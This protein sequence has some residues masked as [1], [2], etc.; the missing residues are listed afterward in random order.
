MMQRLLFCVLA[1]VCIAGSRADAAELCDRTGQPIDITVLPTWP[2]PPGLRRQ[3]VLFVHGHAADSS[4]DPNYRK[5][6]WEDADDDPLLAFFDLTSVKKTLDDT[7]NSGLDIEAYYIRFDDR[8]RSITDDAFET[9]QVVDYIVRR[10]N[11]NFDPST[12]TMPPPVQVAIIGYSKGTISTRQYLKSLQ[13]QVQDNGGISLPPPRPGYRPVSEFIALAQPNHGI[14]SSFFSEATDQI[15]IQQLYN[16]VQPEGPGCGTPFPNLHPQAANFIEILNGEAAIDLQVSNA[17]AAS[18]EAPGSRPPDQGPHTGT[19]YVT[20]FDN[21]DLVGGNSP[22]STDCPGAGRGLASN[23]S[24]QAINITTTVPGAL[25]ATVHRNTPHAQDVVCKALFAVIHHRS[26]EN[27][28]CPLSGRVPIIPLPQP[29]AAMLALD[30]SGSMLARECATCPTRYDILKQA[31]EIF[32][33]LWSLAGRPNDRLGVT[34]FRTTVDEPSIASERL[35]VLTGNAA[36][37]V[38]DVTKPVA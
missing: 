10:H 30:I 4:A 5:N 22:S 12:A 37:V 11:E 34:Y 19:L 1:M 26:P 6:F 24:P 18:G 21:R 20:I 17:A 23:L 9:G 7:V 38:A 29:A 16:G 2:A 33:Q 15:S 8:T 3:P 32:A 36:A 35:P 28:T 25:A 14:S 31:V 13:E 27:Q